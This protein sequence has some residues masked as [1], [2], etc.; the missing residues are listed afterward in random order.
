MLPLQDPGQAHYRTKCNVS[1]RSMCNT[2]SWQTSYHDS[3][4]NVLQCHLNCW[5][6]IWADNSYSCVFRKR[7]GVPQC[8]I[9]SKVLP[10]GTAV[11]AAVEGSEHLK[12]LCCICFLGN[13]PI[14]TGLT[15]ESS[16]AAQPN[17]W[18]HFWHKSP[19]TPQ[20]EQSREVQ[21]IPL[22][23][24]KVKPLGWKRKREKS[25]KWIVRLHLQITDITQMLKKE[26]S[27]GGNSSF[28]F[29]KIYDSD[30]LDITE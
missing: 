12:A 11:L 16:L 17:V 8:W 23:L 20:S 19:P 21:D 27:T 13:S 3:L 7:L 6:Q 25:V 10:Q 5:L 9:S 26:V 2:L 1:L 18:W 28:L 29:R 22:A 24:S 14:R 30:G 15:P 4:L